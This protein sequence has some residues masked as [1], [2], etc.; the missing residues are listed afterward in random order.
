MENHCKKKQVQNLSIKDT[1][2]DWHMLSLI[3]RCPDYRVQIEWKWVSSRMVAEK[4]GIFRILSLIGPILG[5]Y[6]YR[7]VDSCQ[8][9]HGC[10]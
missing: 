8:V 7:P 9:P 2:C 10:R 3:E 6:V 4:Q 1:V 5:W